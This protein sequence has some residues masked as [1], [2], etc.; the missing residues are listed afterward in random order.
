[1]AHGGNPIS[2]YSNTSNVFVAKFK[3]LDPPLSLPNVR[4]CAGQVSIPLTLNNLQLNKSIEAI[5]AKVTFNS[6]VLTPTEVTLTGGVLQNQ[7]YTVTYNKSTPGELS[8][9]IYALNNLFTG[10]GVVAY[11]NFTASGTA[12]TSTPLTFTKSEINASPVSNLSG[13]FTIDGGYTVSGHIGYY[14]TAKNV[15]QTH[16]KLTGSGTFEGDSDIG[17]NY[18]ISNICPAGTYKLTP[19]KTTHLGGLSAMDAGKISMNVVGSEPFDCH[20]KIAADTD[21]DG[22]IT[23][24]DASRIARYLAG[25][26]TCMNDRTPCVEWVFTPNPITGCPS[27]PPDYLYRRPNRNLSSESDRTGFCCDPGR[28]CNGQL[29]YHAYTLC[30]RTS[31]ESDAMRS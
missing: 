15:P 28:R 16:L 17:G 6:T 23:G 24:V 30:K 12:G 1:M 20:Q 14:S 2:P 13:S 19:S 11:L 29:G 22:R 27:W 18:V 5:D 3:N 21:S 10:S 9:T 25:L 7:N 26:I 31:G 4:Q 8:F